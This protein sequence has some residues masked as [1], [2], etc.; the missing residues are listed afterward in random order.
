MSAELL[1]PA[2]PLFHLGPGIRRDERIHSQRDNS[3][4]SGKRYINRY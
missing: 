1:E 2:T 3:T 4:P